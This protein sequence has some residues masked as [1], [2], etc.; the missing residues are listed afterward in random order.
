MTDA[1]LKLNITLRELLASR[2]ISARELSRQTDIPQSTISSMLSPKKAHSAHRPEHLRNLSRFFG[3]TLEY[4]LWKE[5]PPN[6][7]LEQ[8]LTETLY[9]GWLKVKIERAI[10]VSP[11][12]IKIKG[13]SH[14]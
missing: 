6:V 13:V 9:S 2:G 1:P 4:L 14:K 11:D 5:D 12:E 3:V 8:L 7:A 10:T